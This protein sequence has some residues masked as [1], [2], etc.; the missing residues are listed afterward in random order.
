MGIFR[1]L[2]ETFSTKHKV[3]RGLRA[4][5]LD[6]CVIEGRHSIG[7]LLKE[8]DEP[9]GLIKIQNSPIRWVSVIRVS[10]EHYHIDSLGSRS[11]SYRCRNVYIVPDATVVKGEYRFIECVPAKRSRHA[12]QPTDIQWKSRL[13]DR[14]YYRLSEDML[15]NRSLIQL[16]Q[17]IT[18]KSFPG[19][20]CW[21]M[22]SSRFG[23]GAPSRSEWDCYEMIARH[24]LASNVV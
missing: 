8:E 23:S 7:Y 5:G 19:Q 22:Y 16:K 10:S 24:L 9:L 21:S 11:V 6:A 2:V 17:N 1:M 18:I 13:Q 15:L 3:C 14:L 12:S 20:A 4:I